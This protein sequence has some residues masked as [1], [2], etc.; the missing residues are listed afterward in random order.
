MPARLYAIGQR[1]DVNDVPANS[2]AVIVVFVL[3]R[4][5]GGWSTEGS[6]RPCGSGSLQN[7]PTRD[8]LA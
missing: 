2:F 8:F 5:D 6:Q 4:K 3:V 7:L 1:Q